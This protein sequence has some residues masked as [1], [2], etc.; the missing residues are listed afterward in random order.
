M[1]E[2]PLP[3]L[4][5][6][7]GE[8][9][10]V[11]FRAFHESNVRVW[12]RYA[13]L[14][15]GEEQAAEVV[16]DGAFEDL[17]RS[18]PRAL[19]CESVQAFAWGLLREHIAACLEHRRTAFVEVAAFDAVRVVLRSARAKFEIMESALGLYTAISRLPDRQY[20]ALVLRHVL[21]YP[22]DRVALM[23]GSR[24]GTVRSNLRWARR[25]IARELGMTDPEDTL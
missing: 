13:R 23:L 3:V 5:A 7:V 19:T 15:L 16:V 4:S 18:W 14:H 25:R 8:R 12:L 17:A 20:D 1:S 9:L 10:S 21:G 11:T 22:E 2:G 6:P 24:P